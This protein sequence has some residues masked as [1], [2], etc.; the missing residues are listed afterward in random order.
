MWPSGLT[1]VP[2]GELQ[3][4]EGHVMGCPCSWSHIRGPFSLKGYIHKT[5]LTLRVIGEPWGQISPE[6]AELT[7]RGAN[8]C[9]SG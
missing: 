4:P 7:L 9:P 2:K 1:G 3:F 6:T 5:F 8:L